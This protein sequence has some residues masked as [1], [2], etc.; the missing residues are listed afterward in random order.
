[1]QVASNLLEFCNISLVFSSR[2]SL[3]I[4]LSPQEPSHAPL[5][6]L[7]CNASGPDLQYKEKMTRSI[8]LT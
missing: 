1:M 8:K 5:T 6:S 3:S 7:P 4:F 2:P